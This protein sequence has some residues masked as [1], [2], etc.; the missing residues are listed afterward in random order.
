MKSLRTLSLLGALAVSGALL[1]QDAKVPARE[2]FAI[3]GARIELGDGRS[4]AS[5][6]VLVSNGTISS[7]IDTPTAPLPPDY[8]IVKADGKIL[9]PG[10]IDC[11]STK[12]V[13][14]PP[15]PSDAG[16]PDTATKAPPTM[17]IGNRKGIF[18]EWKAA[19]N[20]TFEPDND[21]YQEGV[22]MMQLSSS[23][24]GMRGL[25]TVIDLLPSS[26][27][28]RYIRD[29]NALAMTFRL[30]AGSGYPSNILGTIALLRQVWA[31]AAS[32]KDGAQLYEGD[33]KPSWMASLEALQPA[34]N[35]R[36]PVV[37]EASMDREID[38]VFRM[39]KEFGFKPIIQG[40]RDA[41]KVI[42]SIQA[43]EAS[44]ILNADPGFMP[45]T[46]PPSKDTPPA[47]ATPLE[48]K[49]ERF[50]RWEAQSRCAADLA[51]AK[52]KFGFCSE[53]STNRL[54]ENVRNL[55][56]RGLGRDAALRALTVDAADILG[57]NAGLIE[58]GR[59]ANLVLFD[60]DFS[61]AKSKA[62]MV[63]VDGRQV[64]ADKE[65]SK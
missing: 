52:V 40:A 49:K 34:L 36:M 16:K 4:I 51:A 21:N 53:G 30:G 50:A 38:R 9:Y 7:V 41:N 5:G 33:K 8:Q 10:F 54:L 46:D 23:R 27:K 45:N 3:V 19:A 24:G 56:S 18:P 22:T 17:W 31:D 65:G 1:A 48:Y 63:W 25:T 28:S 2:K 47:D 32:L 39:S 20:C 14:T 57:V 43:N 59:K 64:Y 12:G 55:V 60:A 44:V 11:F 42:K 58:N 29:D 26:E 35:R 13:T 15:D 6:T 37:F 61:N 62:V